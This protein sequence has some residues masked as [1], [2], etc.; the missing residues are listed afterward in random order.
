MRLGEFTYP[1]LILNAAARQDP[2]SGFDSLA[3]WLHQDIS[4]TT[5]SLRRWFTPCVVIL[6]GMLVLT[7]AS[8]LHI[9]LGGVW[10]LFFVP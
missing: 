6:L 8:T 7:I 10:K 4:H 3:E 2:L 9:M 1:W 5:R